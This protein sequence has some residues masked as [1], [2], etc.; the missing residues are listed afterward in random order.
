M[1]LGD[2][3][4]RYRENIFVKKFWVKIFFHDVILERN[5]FAVV[6]LHGIVW[7]LF[8]MMGTGTTDSPLVIHYSVF[9]RVDLLGSARMLFLIPLAGF[10]ILVVNWFLARALYPVLRTG[11][12]VLVSAANVSQL[13]V[14]LNFITLAMRN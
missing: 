7:V 2:P 12:Y 13:I 10:A 14:I 8:F 9:R 1:I 4:K 11:S 3:L 5:F 6:F